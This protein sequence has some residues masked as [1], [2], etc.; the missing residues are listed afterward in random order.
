MGNRQD[1][2]EYEFF[3]DVK[4]IRFNDEEGM[5]T[6]ILEEGHDVVFS[7]TQPVVSKMRNLEHIILLTNTKTG[8]KIVN[9]EYMD[10]LNRVLS[11]TGMSKEGMIDSLDQSYEKFNEE[12]NNKPSETTPSVPVPLISYNYNRS[13]AVSYAHQYAYNYNSAYH[14][15][16]NN[17]CTNFVSQ[18]I[19]EGGGISEE[20]DGGQWYGWYY[21]SAANYASA[22]TGVQQLYDFITVPA[23]WNEGP[24]GYSAT[25]I[26]SM[27]TG[28]V[29]QYKWPGSNYWGHSVIVVTRTSGDPIVTVAAHDIDHDYYPYSYYIYGGIRY[30][31]ITGEW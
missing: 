19:H 27:A 21:S 29:I 25:S 11:E 14:D 26:W 16:T 20:D 1:Y 10:Y 18:A 8:W 3:I 2:V 6:V 22:W 13:G 31:H 7:S 9:D 24:T 23:G 17:D 28:D 12:I 4:D 5:A 30:I 15:F